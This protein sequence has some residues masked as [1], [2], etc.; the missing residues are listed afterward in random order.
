[1]ERCFKLFLADIIVLYK[2]ASRDLKLATKS[3]TE[4]SFK[5][6]VKQSYKLGYI[7]TGLQVSII[8]W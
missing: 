6:V 8:K 2:A 4:H 7:T 1:M 3:T 5:I